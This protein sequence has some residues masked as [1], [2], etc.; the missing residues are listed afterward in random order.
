VESWAAANPPTHRTGSFG[1]FV[2]FKSGVRC[3]Q[4]HAG[5]SDGPA[6]VGADMGE[7]VSPDY[8]PRGNQF[9]GKIKWVQ[10]DI[11]AVARD[12]DHMIGSEEPLQPRNG[13][14]VRIASHEHHFSFGNQVNIQFG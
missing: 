4:I 10:I 2:R 11:D 5:P 1:S 6:S 7:P 3:Q 9:S 8:G 14:A 12:A 13:T